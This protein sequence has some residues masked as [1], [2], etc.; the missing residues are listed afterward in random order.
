[1]KYKLS[2]SKCGTEFS[3]DESKITARLNDN[4][5][6]YPEDLPNR[7]IICGGDLI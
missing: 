6:K 2:C 3:F 7:C 4:V 5:V 1:M